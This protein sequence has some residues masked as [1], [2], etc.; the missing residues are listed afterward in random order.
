MIASGSAQ[1]AYQGLFMDKREFSLLFFYKNKLGSWE[2]ICNN[3]RG[4]IINILLNKWL[5]ES[6]V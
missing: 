3:I 1:S 4:A 5:K 6:K 2:F